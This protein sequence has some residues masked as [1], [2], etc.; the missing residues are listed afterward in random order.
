LVAIKI[1]NV[2]HAEPK[3][4]PLIKALG[5]S[6][7]AEPAK[8]SSSRSPRMTTKEKVEKIA[9]YLKGK[10]KVPTPEIEAATGIKQLGAILNGEMKKQVTKGG[11]GG[12]K[13]FH[14]TLK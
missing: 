13:G 9:A 14:W 4:E 5:L 6:L 2:L 8:R 10:S 3:F 7:K 1:P 11:D 12:K